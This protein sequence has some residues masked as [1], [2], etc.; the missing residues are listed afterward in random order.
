MAEEKSFWQRFVD[1]ALL[2]KD[3]TVR[4]AAVMRPEITWSPIFL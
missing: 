1:A 4:K 3:W 2:D